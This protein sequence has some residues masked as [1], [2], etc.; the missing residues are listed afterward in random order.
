[1][2][3]DWRPQ[4]GG[5]LAAATVV[6]LLAGPVFAQSQG[7]D[8]DWPCEQRLVPSLAAAQMWRGPV[9]EGVAKD[10]PLDPSLV[11]LAPRLADR[12]A[13]LEGLRGETGAAVARVPGEARAQQLALLFDTV[14]VR[15]N[16]MR[17]NEI[18]GVRRFAVK[19]RDLARRITTETRELAAA[20]PDGTRVATDVA[21]QERATAQLWDRRVFDERQRSLR[22]LCAQ[23]VLLDQ[24]AF[25]VARMLGEF[26]P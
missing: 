22:T 4:L 8:P 11:P 18:N 24:R 23:P 14:L 25:A 19:Q 1:M 13:G 2:M 3:V 26:L 20:D 7:H 9:V 21:L 16:E 5:M 12:S 10:V 17:T 15:I 6:S